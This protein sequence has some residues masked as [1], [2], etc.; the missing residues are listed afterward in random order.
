MLVETLNHGRLVFARFAKF[1]WHAADTETVA[2]AGFIKRDALV[3]GRSDLIIFSICYKGESYS[4]PTSFFDPQY[5]TPSEWASLYRP[6]AQSRKIIKTFQNG[7][8]DLQVFFNHNILDFKNYWDTMVG[9]WL[10]NENVSKGLKERAPLYGRFLRETKTVD[11]S[12][13][14]ALSEYAEQDVVQ[15][16]EMYQMQRFGFI[17]RPAT[18]L[19]LNAKGMLIAEKN[20][21]DP[22]K[23][24]IDGES[25]SDFNRLFLRLHEMPV[26]RATA[27]AERRGFPYNLEKQD[28]ICEKIDQDK[29]AIEKR[30]YRQFGRVFNLNSKDQLAEAL[31]DLGVEIPFK[32]K[33]GK[34]S[35]SKPN[36]VKMQ[37]LHPIIPDLIQL[38]KVAKLQSVYIGDWTSGK[39]KDAEDESAEEGAEEEELSEDQQEEIEAMDEKKKK[40]NRVGLKAFVNFE[41]DRIHCTINTVGAR[42][43]R[44]SASTPNLQQLPQ[45]ADIYGIRECF[46]APKGK[47][48][49]VLD[50][51]Q[52]EIRVMDFWADDA[53]MTKV[54][55]DPKGD[56]HQMTADHFKVARN[57]TAKNLNF[58]MLFGGQAFMLAENLTKEGVPT[59][60]QE[61]QLFLDGYDSTLYPG[62]KQ[63]RLKMLAFHKANGFCYYL[64][65]RRRTIP[66]VDWDD[67]YVVHK[68]ETVL[69]NNLIQGTGQDFIKAMIIRSDPLC[70]N[71]DRAAREELV[72]KPSHRNLLC[73]YT[74]KVS[75]L[76]HKFRLAHLQWILQ[77]HDEV[78]YFVDKHAAEETL[79]DL[80]DL[81]TWRHFFPATVKYNVPLV[82]EGGV[83]ENWKQAKS[84]TPIFHATAGYDN[85]EPE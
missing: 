40:K 74:A 24:I 4:F 55:C 57:P 6:L 42:T 23:I 62:V 45:R 7:K 75:R 28:L 11:F 84:K 77:V 5:P 38:S 20:I 67:K 35:V 39:K 30:I 64:T 29:T 26:I 16:D 70:I 78:I 59:S 81:M 71:P 66:N 3:Y 14:K 2:S 36:L 37:A 49:V 32:T 72:M 41:N 25:L 76:R 33:G 13:L 21:F 69:A 17:D 27:R 60:Q 73:D 50:Y 80:A 52:L 31:E 82:T 1:P 68:T 63:A 15:T 46:H 44:S 58:L 47:L 19:Q 8:Y 10:A 79:N 85:W 34:P 56:L 18:L 22:G 61:A 83:G 43:G 48:M 65:G 53:N 51:A 54:L 12:D 9:A